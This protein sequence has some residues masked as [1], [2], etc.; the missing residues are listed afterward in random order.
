VPSLAV[1][2]EHAHYASFDATPASLSTNCESESL[3]D[4][5]YKIIRDELYNVAASTLP[6]AV[7]LLA[8]Y[9]TISRVSGFSDDDLVVLAST[10]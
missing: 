4:P 5:L 10:L 9:A 3:L 6:W 7:Q 8:P 2:V 1:D